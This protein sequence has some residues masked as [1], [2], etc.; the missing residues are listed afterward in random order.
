MR[1]RFNELCIEVTK[2]REELKEQRELIDFLLQHDRNEVA[3]YQ[4]MPFFDNY[5]EL[6]AKYI[7]NCEIKCLKICGCTWGRDDGEVG[8]VIAHPNVQE[9]IE[10]TEEKFVVKVSNKDNLFKPIYYKVFKHNG[11]VADVTEYYQQEEPPTVANPDTPTETDFK[12]FT[13]DQVRNMSQKE[14]KENYADIMKSMKK[15]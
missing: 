2:N 15:W 1:K 6:W 3:F 12:Y 11:K 5:R 8:I 10:N 9:L 14:V 13:A 7:Y 4:Q